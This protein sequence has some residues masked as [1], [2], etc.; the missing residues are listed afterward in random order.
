M[1]L[2]DLAQKCVQLA[3]TLW[4]L[5]DLQSSLQKSPQQPA[6][7]EENINIFWCIFILETSVPMNASRR[8][9]S[10][11]VTEMPLPL[12]QPGN[13]G[14]THFLAA[15]RVARLRHNVLVTG[16]TFPPMHTGQGLAIR[17]L[18]ELQNLQ[19]TLDIDVAGP[20]APCPITNDFQLWTTLSCLTTRLMINETF[21]GSQYRD[22]VLS[23][24][25]NAI[26][27]LISIGID[28][29]ENLE[30]QPLLPLYL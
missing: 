7:A 28:T 17:H 12:E 21:P 6:I 8:I 2:T 19:S 30:N 24:A 9:P 1:C 18:E 27:I 15:I 5:L 4:R 25:Q 13:R 16:T 14:R 10:S 29:G 26:L 22:S 20:F 23:T 3:P 11:T